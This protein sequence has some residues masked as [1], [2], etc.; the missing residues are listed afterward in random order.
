MMF[1][2]N[3]VCLQLS[4]TVVLSCEN[5]VF[6]WLQLIEGSNNYEIIFSCSQIMHALTTFSKLWTYILKLYK[7]ISY[8]LS[9]YYYFMILFLWKSFIFDIFMNILI[10]PCHS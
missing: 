10:I 9:L 8:F 4:F 2:S 1:V 7:K 6:V 3:F 5:V